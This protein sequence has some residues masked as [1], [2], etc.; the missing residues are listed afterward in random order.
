[1]SNSPASQVKRFMRLAPSNGS[2]VFSFTNGNPVIRFSVADAQAMLIGKEMR[3]CGKL[4][5]FVQ[6]YTQIHTVQKE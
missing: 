5:I 2:G 4:V 6:R 1:M 3:F